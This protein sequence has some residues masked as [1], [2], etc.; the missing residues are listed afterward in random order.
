MSACTFT[1]AL[2]CQTCA[3]RQ[4]QSHQFSG[5]FPASSLL[6]ITLDL[7]VIDYFLFLSLV[8]SHCHVVVV[9]MHSDGARVCVWKN[10]NGFHLYGPIT[11]VRYVL[12]ASKSRPIPALSITTTSTQIHTQTG[13]QGWH[14]G[15]V[16]KTWISLRRIQDFGFLQVLCF[17]FGD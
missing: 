10:L 5:V 1:H 14:G 15:P 17:A 3:R 6:L 9:C 16:G 7:G 4:N 8:C 2:L 11:T 12:D 13:V